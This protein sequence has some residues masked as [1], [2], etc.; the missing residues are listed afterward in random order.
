MRGTN[1]SAIDVDRS[2]EAQPTTRD[3]INPEMDEHLIRRRFDPLNWDK[4]R[5]VAMF[6][7]SR[8]MQYRG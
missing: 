2:A 5:F 6:N 8:V 7:Y 3:P 4:A 1:Q